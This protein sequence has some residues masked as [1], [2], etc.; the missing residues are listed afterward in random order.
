M[1]KFVHKVAVFFY[2]TFMDP[3]VLRVHQVSATDV[4]PASVQGFELVIE[5]RV[6]LRAVEASSV[7]GSIVSVTHAEL[8]RLYGGLKETFGLTYL[9]Y[10][11]LAT[12]TSGEVRPALCYV[13]QHMEP[14]PADP[15]YVTE[16]ANC[17]RALGH[18]EWYAL[19]VESFS[20]Q[21]GRPASPPT[22]QE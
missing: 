14:G 9:P 11:V 18:P 10:A 13:A 12:T 8:E 1:N 17:V 16:L 6:N 21:S 19:H 22:D 15:G 3:T 4:T 2:G 20:V 7:F 5:P